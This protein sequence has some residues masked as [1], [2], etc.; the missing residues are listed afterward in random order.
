MVNSLYLSLIHFRVFLIDGEQA[1]V[2]DNISSKF[3][4]KKTLTAKNSLLLY[5]FKT[6]ARVSVICDFDNEFIFVVVFLGFS[7][8]FASRH[9]DFRFW[10]VDFQLG[11]LALACA[12]AFDELV[13]DFG[14]FEI[15]RQR[16]TGRIFHRFRTETATFL[17]GT[18]NEAVTFVD[19]F[20]DL[21]DGFVS[22]ERVTLRSRR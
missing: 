3:N 19:G 10:A 13:D 16:N 6:F 14:G 5:S 11:H 15:P 9:Q 2:M 22:G 20:H 8:T 21:R 18:L 4:N 7:R 12:F 17:F 1:K